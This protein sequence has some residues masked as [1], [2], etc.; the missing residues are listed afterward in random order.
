MTRYGIPAA[1]LALLMTTSAQAALK[2]VATTSDY[3]AIATTIGGDKVSVATLAKPSDDPHVKGANAGTVSLG[4]ADV[5]I[6]SG[7]KLEAG[8]LPALLDGAPGPK[9]RIRASEGIQLLD[10]D[11]HFMM[12]PMNAGIVAKHVTEVFCGLD[13]ASCDAYKANLT[14]FQSKLDAKTKEWAA[15]LAPFKGRA[16]VTYHASWRYFAQR[17]G[18]VS[19]WHLEPQPGTAPTT[20][21]MAGVMSKMIG[22]N[23]HVL[24]VEPFQPHDIAS[25]V[26][27][28]TRT[29]LV[30][31]SQFPVD[32]DYLALIDADVQAILTALQATV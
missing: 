4:D 1:A 6:E 12:D 13:A 16:I 32:G 14:E 17:F 22:R 18:L 8:W 2:V 31:V 28:R 21:H 10:G 5:L 24:L 27:R 15:A 29:R 3:G 23:V 11:P 25:A 30:E 19:E 7:T 9:A 26:A 20:E